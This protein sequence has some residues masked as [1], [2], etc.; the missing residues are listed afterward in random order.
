MKVLLTVFVLSILCVPV[1]S[2]I[3]GI[4]AKGRGDTRIAPG[5]GPYRYDRYPFGSFFEDPGLDSS[6]Y[7]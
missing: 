5:P 3:D 4:Y 7:Q 2:S 1:L 6:D